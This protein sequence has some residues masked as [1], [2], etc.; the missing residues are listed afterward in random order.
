MF[1]HIVAAAA[2]PVLAQNQ[3]KRYAAQAPQMIAQRELA[4]LQAADRRRHQPQPSFR[5]AL[6]R[7]SVRL[8]GGASEPVATS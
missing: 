8:V 3:E 4:L 6:A 5:H 7:L 1:E 2:G